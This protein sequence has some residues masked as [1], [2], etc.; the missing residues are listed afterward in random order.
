YALSWLIDHEIDLS[1]FDA[2]FGNDDTGA[3][4]YDPGV[5]LKIVLYAYSRGLV[6]SR[7]IERA[8]RDN[9]VM[10]ALSGDTQP[11]FTTLAGFVSSL[12]AEITQVFRD[13]LL[14]CDE[15]GLIGKQ[16]FAVDGCKLPSNA[17]KEWSGTR[18]DF[19]R[20]ADKMEKAVEYLL[21]QH[22]ARDVGECDDEIIERERRQIQT[23][24]ES[25]GKLRQWLKSN[26][27]DKR[28][29]SGKPVKSNLT[30]NHSALMKTGHGVI[31]GYTGV[32]AVDSE[33]QVV[34]HAEAFGVGQENALLPQ[35]LDA[36]AEHFESLGQPDAL[37]D[38]AVTADAG[39]HSEDTLKKLA[40][41]E[42]DAY[43][44]DTNFRKRDPR[45]AEAYRH[46]PEERQRVPG[47]RR[48]QWYQAQDFDFN[49]DALS[50]RCPA[51]QVLKLSTR[52]A[53]I[54]GMRA[55]IFEGTRQTCGNCPLRVKCLRKPDV[56]PYRQV[57]FFGDKVYDRHPHT[58]RMKQKIDSR[59][60]RAIYARRLGTVEP[61]FAHL[62]GRGL[63]RFTLRSRRK[64]DAQWKLF[65]IVHNVQKIRRYG[66]V[67]RV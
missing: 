66:T 61:V 16:M 13:V 4:A 46:K 38:V 22:Q 32:A 5:L 27:E 7:S 24:R 40:D 52:N 41:Q 8:C 49:P 45:F 55:I 60:G 42:I 64:V 47:E 36:T 57:A 29:L 12:S 31:Q 58:H 9:V 30:D 67:G 23:L 19:Q 6:S 28:G 44:A 21:S 1:V 26:A 35:V 3:T 43:V 15:Q 14:V 50:C 17:A 25:S 2:R 53:V 10:M 33:H 63:H 54:K 56:S 65:C 51:G 18:A 59:Q 48:S 11:H 39:Y 20:K 37:K 62:R 34:V